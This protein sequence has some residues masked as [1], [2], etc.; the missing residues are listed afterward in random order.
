[1][2]S[3][4]C[5]G[6]QV[7]ATAFTMASSS[8]EQNGGR[9]FI[10]REVWRLL[11]G[12]AGQPSQ[13]DH[14]SGEHDRRRDPRSHPEAVNERR[15]DRSLHCAAG[16]RPGHLTRLPGD[17]DTCADRITGDALSIGRKCRSGQQFAEAR[18]VDGCERLPPA[19]TH[20]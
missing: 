1:M 13:G 9:R 11:R 2:H 7:Q 3:E 17:L 15:V 18:R 12:V 10:Q 20:P 16:L 14:C 19:A 5:A 6:V 8:L 4:R